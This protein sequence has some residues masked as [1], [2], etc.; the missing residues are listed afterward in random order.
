VKVTNDGGATWSEAGEAEGA[1]AF[2]NR[3]ENGVLTTYAV[4]GGVE[5][6]DGVQVAKVVRG[7]EPA[8][9]ACLETTEPTPGSV[10]I[11]ASPQAGWLIVGD[12]TWVSGADLT[13]WER[14]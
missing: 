3:I 9:V 11:S 10:A 7:E 4:R 12:D 1:L 13:A 5:G 6:C 8:D 2:S 14:A